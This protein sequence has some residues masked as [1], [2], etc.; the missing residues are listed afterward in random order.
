LSPPTAI[1][2]E[3]LEPDDDPELLADWRRHGTALT[4]SEGETR[5]IDLKLSGS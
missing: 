1:A 5:T 2:V 4:L 3:Y